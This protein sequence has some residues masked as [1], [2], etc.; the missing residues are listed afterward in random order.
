MTGND[1]I[2]GSSTRRQGKISIKK[3]V[4]IESYG[5]EEH[6]GL[7]TVNIQLKMKITTVQRLWLFHVILKVYKIRTKK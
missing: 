2:A 5:S 4:W 1:Q 7:D 6:K 3:I